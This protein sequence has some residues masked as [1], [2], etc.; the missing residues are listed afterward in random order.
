M[1]KTLKACC[2]VVLQAFV[3]FNPPVLTRVLRAVPF[4]PYETRV[5]FDA[6]PRPYYAFGIMQAAQEARQLKMR[7]ISVV[8]F[9]VANGGGLLE[10]EKIARH[11]ERVTG[12]AID[13]YGFDGGAG[14]PAPEDYRDLPFYWQ[15]G[16]YPMEE[17]KLRKRLQRAK[18]I[19]GDVKR[20][21]PSFLKRTFAPIGF[22]AFDLDLYSSTKRAM[23]LMKA[24]PQQI[25]PRVYCYFDDIGGGPPHNDRIGVL[26]VIKEFNDENPQRYLAPFFRLQSLR[27]AP[28]FW[29]EQIYV[30]HD[31]HHQKYTAF[32]GGP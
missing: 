8:E 29:N 19:I 6:L 12:V 20:T 18:L 9:G 1:F 11:V 17:K 4:L 25:L 2:R 14:L 21:V 27:P 32:T 3:R 13:V 28:Q 16:M 15:T 23:Q 24:K 5:A 26:L 31:F 10:M 7:R 30:L 22:I